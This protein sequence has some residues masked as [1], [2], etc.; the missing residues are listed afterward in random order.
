M[1]RFGLSLILA[2]AIASP[3]LLTAQRIDEARVAMHNSS[4]DV[5]TAQTP[6]SLSV[7]SRTSASTGS[8]VMG[9]MV[10]GILGAFAGAAVGISAENC[11][12]TQDDYCGIAGGVIGGLLGEAIGVPIGVNWAANG[13]GTLG[14][15]IPASIAMSVVCVALG[16]ATSGTSIL[17]IPPMQI[18]TSI[19]AERTGK[20]GFLA[21]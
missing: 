13:S 11:Q 9:G 14:K 4:T 18:Y 8:M 2:V 7:A 12:R 15:T 10:G 6:A 3:S 5:S 16:F 19:R 17:M 20:S 21:W 1:R